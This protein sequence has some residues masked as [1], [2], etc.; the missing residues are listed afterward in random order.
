MVF[1]T[2]KEHIVILHPRHGEGDPF[3]LLGCLVDCKLTMQ[4]AIDQLLS[5]IRPKVK[6]IVRTR[7]H[8]AVKDLISQFKTHI[9]GLMECHN[10]GIFHACSSLLEKLDAI[11]FKFLRDIG[12]DHANAFLEFNFAPPT[13]RRN[14]SILGLLH[15]RVLGLSHPMFQTLLPFCSDVPGAWSP[16]DHNKQLYGHL[17]EANFQLALFCRSI[18]GMTYVYNRLPQEIVDN[19]TV[20]LFQNSLTRI[21]RE[22]CENGDPDWIHLFSSRK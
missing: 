5:Q 6:A 22:M 14:I 20:S 16:G 12:S 10:G 7:S 2:E 3:K 13:L 21:A 15:K 1:D 18:F 17:P 8:Y 9:W 19:Q 4:Q 11:H